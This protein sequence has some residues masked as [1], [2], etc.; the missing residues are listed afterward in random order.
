MAYRN[1]R[2]EATHV[3][4]KYIFDNALIGMLMLSSDGF[5]ISCNREAEKLFGDHEKL[6]CKSFHDLFITDSSVDLKKLFGNRNENKNS[7]WENIL[8]INQNNKEV[9]WVNVRLSRVTIASDG[10]QQILCQAHKITT[11]TNEDDDF[12]Y[13][14]NLLLE[15]INNIPDNIFIKDVK[16]RFILANE[17]VVRLMGADS[18]KALT[19]KTDSDFYPKKLAG[20]YRKDE[21]EI[22]ESGKAKLNI[23]EQVIDR[24]HNRKWYSTSKLPLKNNNGEIIGIMGIGRDITLLVK[25]QKALRKAKHEAEKADKLKSAFLANLSHEIRTPLNGILGFSQ[26]LSQYIPPDPK[27]QKYI[28]FILQNG[29][30]LLHLISDIIDVSKIES[31]QL[32]IKKKLFSLNEIFRQMDQS[33]REELRLYDKTNITLKLELFFPDDESYIY[34]DD[35]RIK[36][37]LHNLLL[38]AVK[39]TQKGTIDFGYRIAEEQLFFYVKDTGIGIKDEDCHAIFE[40][41]TQVDNSLGRQFE[42][43]G[44]G[45]SIAKGLVTL[46]GGKIGV[47]SNY[48]KGSE[49]F[50][51]LPYVNKV[52]FHDLE[53]NDSAGLEQKKILFIGSHPETTEMLKSD[54]FLK[55]IHTDFAADKDACLKYFE[56]EYKPELI[57]CNMIHNKEWLQEQIRI[58]LKGHPESSLLLITDS[59]TNFLLNDIINDKR[60]ETIKEPV[61]TYLLIEK[62]KLLLR[63]SG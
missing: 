30:R 51:I 24:N 12:E 1:T 25:E 63:N 19:G 55:N 23:I 38:N 32:V 9:I 3:F 33:V 28:D 43:A 45:L 13:Y 21:M 36:Q 62:I 35:Q 48:G 52:P 46:L 40:L 27:A 59:R 7:N 17:N 4:Q 20:K 18:P 50:F 60:I 22:I 2:K 54:P 26:F 39:F 47:N 42:G 15:L 16:S 44:L 10:Q 11:P 37:V 29:K 58:Y 53:K 61:N 34:E 31:N 8:R 41:F 49:F 14:N 57:I 56:S 5:V 6:T